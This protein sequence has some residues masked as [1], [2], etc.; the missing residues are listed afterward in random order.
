ML[1]IAAYLKAKGNNFHPIF[2]K[3][4]K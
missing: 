3:L 2:N 4:L 1:L